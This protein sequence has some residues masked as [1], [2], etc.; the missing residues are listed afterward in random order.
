MVANIAEKCFPEKVREADLMPAHVGL[1]S[2][3][4]RRFSAVIATWNILGNRLN[5]FRMIDNF[6]VIVLKHDVNERGI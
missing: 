6:I 2:H 1:G 3:S 5:G 4:H